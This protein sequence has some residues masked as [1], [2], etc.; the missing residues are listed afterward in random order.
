M[1]KALSLLLAL[2]L[3]LAS[4][5][6]L[7]SCKKKTSDDATVSV[8]YLSG[9]T[10]LGLAKLIAD[11]ADNEKMKFTKYNSPAEIMA[12]Y[13]KGE[14][15][16]A[17]LP[18]NG[19][20][21]FKQNFK[22]KRDFQMIALNEYGVLY[23]LVRNGEPILPSDLSSLSG[24]TIYVPE[25]APKLILEHVLKE[26]GVENVT[27]SLEY[28]LDSVNAALADQNVE[29][30]LLPE[31]KVTVATNQN[32]AFT[33]ALDLTEAW[34]LVSDKALVQGCMIVS[35]TFAEAHGATVDAFL[36]EYKNSINWMKNAENL[37][38]AAQYAVSAEI[39]PNAA[40]AKKAIP[41]C[42]LTFMAG[43]EMQET[44]NA[45]FSALGIAEQ[46]IS[47][48]YGITDDKME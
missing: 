23:L 33:V 15:D 30:L 14:I 1:K 24:K 5:L 42:N 44:V 37:D 19:F 22:D 12:A 45:F 8:G 35:K 3:L 10:G 48:F 7:A 38:T 4:L 13:S 6:S 46:P 20:P 18:T 34:D 29:Y 41:R 16:F 39:L 17:T 21:Q 40:V 31:P 26:N 43:E 28:N 9:P 2:T 27:V 47:S 25:Q 36:T 11:N 32:P